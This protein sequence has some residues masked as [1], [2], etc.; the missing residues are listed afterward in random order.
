MITLSEHTEA[1]AL[2]HAWCVPPPR[3]TELPVNVLQEIRAAA[4]RS[5]KLSNWAEAEQLLSSVAGDPRLGIADMVALGT[6]RLRLG[7]AA[8]CWRVIEGVLTREP[9]HLRAAQ[10]GSMA[11]VMQHR[12]TEALVL[13]ERHATGPAREDYAFVANHAAAL[14][15]LGRPGDAIPVLLEAMMLKVNDPSPHMKLGLVLRDM[16]LFQEA[17]E[18]F[19]T[20]FTLDPNKLA[21]QLAVMHMRQHACRWDEFDSMRTAIVD[22][23]AADPDRAG[24]LA[25]GGVFTLVAIEHPPEL[26]L[27][28]TSRVAMRFDHIATPLPARR[29]DPDRDRP[30]RI[31]YV[32]N[33]F[34][35]HATSALLVESLEH[36]DRS[37][38][39]VTLYS[40]SKHDGSGLEQRVRSACEHFVD[41]STLSD[42]D[43]AQRIRA[44][45]IDILVDLKGHTLGNR[46]AI[47]AWRPAPLQVSFL[48]FPGTSGASYIDYVIGDRW[49]TPLAHADR[50][51]ER[52][53][54]M[55][56]CYQPNDSRRP[57]PAPVGRS[58]LGLP[59]DRLVLGCFNQA[60]KISPA[61]F[62]VWMRILAA[63]PDSVLWLLEDNPQATVNLRR[64]AVAR[65]IAAERLIFAPRVPMTRHLARLP[66]ADLMLDNWPCNAHTTASDILWMGVPMLT[67]EGE[68]FASRVAGS[69]LRSLDLPELVCA[70]AAA[71]ESTAIALLREP[72]RLLAL[73]ERVQQSAAQSPLFDGAQHARGLE[74]LYDRMVER[75]ANGQPPAA[76]PAADRV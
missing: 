59:Q 70:D 74:N 8:G 12:W 17:A 73:R 31:G 4:Y 61:T 48:G 21:A 18:S 66:A 52:I 75:A 76:L 58:E 1:G 38:F 50:Y 11:L 69:L 43:A 39:E 32:S 29:I 60:F 55:P 45:E 63:V 40:H 54:Q 23:L 27:R 44:D 14:A 26:L 28:A 3:R 37:R 24:S 10:I 5:I 30:L 20:A 53:A 25:E 2:A 62:D 41:I 64:E 49:V 9:S 34:Y 16:N 72:H 56:G 51:S 68:A 22:V 71:Y 13:F 57:R 33:D 36:R 6:L 65:G 15:S 19:L 35:N 47:F 67:I 42:A 46:L 7:D